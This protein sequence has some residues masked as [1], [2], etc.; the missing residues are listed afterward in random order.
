MFYGCENLN[1]VEL[2]NTSNVTTFSNCFSNS[3]KTSYN[4]LYRVGQ[5]DCSSVTTGGTSNMFLYQKGIVEM[6]GLKNLG[7]NFEPLTKAFSFNLSYPTNLSDDSLVNLVSSL[8]DVNGILNGYTCTLN[9]ANSLV[10]RIP[11]DV[12]AEATNKGWTIA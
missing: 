1:D 11:E 9:I 2:M 3:A 5:I 12:I 8:G 10:S 7:M 4:Q 6:G